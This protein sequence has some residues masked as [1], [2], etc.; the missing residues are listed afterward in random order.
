MF[1][2]ISIITEDLLI[3]SHGCM[4]RTVADVIVYIP[5]V[6]S[7]THPIRSYPLG[8]TV[9]NEIIM[10]LQLWSYYS[11]ILKVTSLVRL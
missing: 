4:N 6:P 2:D 3:G 7:R 5:N 10:Q 9:P 11:I 1:L 8:I